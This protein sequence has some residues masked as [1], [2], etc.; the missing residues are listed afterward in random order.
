MPVTLP[1]GQ[2][3]GCRLERSRQWAM[4]CYHEAS[5]FEHNCF[6][7]LTFNSQ[8][9]PE[10]MSL[11][12]RDWQLFMKKLRKKYGSGIR[13]FHCGE[14]GSHKGRPHYHACLFNFDFPDK[15]LW[16]IKNGYPLYRSPSLE[17]LWPYGYSTIGEVTFESAAYVARYIMKKIT[18]EAAEEH[19]QY[20]DPETG[21]IFDRKPEYTT[22]SRRPGIGKK[23]FEQFASDVYPSDFVVV[24]GKKLKPPKYYDGL[25]EV[26]DPDAFNKIKGERR[27]SAKQHIDNNTPERLIIRERVQL[28]KLARLERNHDNG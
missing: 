17:E 5:L 21:E 9:L 4:R 23:W 19:Y 7:T 20:V 6:I 14:Y 27:K 3:V 11:D 18:G 16:Q 26:E 2:C 24:N 15:K 25:F 1:C 12:V 22:M 8:H 10:D 13:F 28:N